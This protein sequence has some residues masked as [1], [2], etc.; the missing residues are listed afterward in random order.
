M[1]SVSEPPSPS[2]SHC[3]R[4]LDEMPLSR[5][6][7]PHRADQASIA[8]LDL[9]RASRL[10]SPKSRDPL[11]FL[12]SAE[13]CF[14]TTSD[15]SGDARRAHL[16]GLQAIRFATARR[17]CDGEACENLGH[18]LFLLESNAS[19]VTAAYGLDS[20][21]L[22]GR[23]YDDHGDSAKHRPDTS[24]HQWSHRRASLP[25]RSRGHDHR[26]QPRLRHGLAAQV[27]V[28]QACGDRAEDRRL[29]AQGPGQARAGRSSTAR[30]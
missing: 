25:A 3:L 27:G 1:H 17:F 19:D 11:E 13:S 7:S 16:E 14:L 12:R 15:Q 10:R 18:R 28:A 22:R 6:A 30:S 29:R 26:P 4:T 23:A 2:S 20:T 8:P 24:D 21:E 5:A 9:D